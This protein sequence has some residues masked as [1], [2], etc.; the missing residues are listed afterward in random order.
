MSRRELPAPAYFAIHR[1]FPLPPRRKKG[2]KH[3]GLPI[4]ATINALEIGD[5]FFFHAEHTS[6]VRSIAWIVKEETGKRFAVRDVDGTRMGIW[7][8]EPNPEGDA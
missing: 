5:C 7:R 3:S 8:V 1:G 4:K 6:K 2:R